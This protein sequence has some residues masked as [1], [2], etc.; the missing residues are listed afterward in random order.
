[1]REILDEEIKSVNKTLFKNVVTEF[2]WRRNY[3]LVEENMNV[4]Q[5]SCSFH[6]LDLNFT[7]EK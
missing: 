1:M 4:F 2:S 5:F 7:L 6:T 3:V